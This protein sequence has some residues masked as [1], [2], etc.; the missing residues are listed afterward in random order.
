MMVGGA[1]VDN[2]FAQSFG[3][4]YSSDA[5]SAVKLAEKLIKIKRGMSYGRLFKI[6]ILF[7]GR[8]ITEALGGAFPYIVTGAVIVAIWIY[9]LL[10]VPKKQ[11]RY[12]LS[13]ST[14][15]M[16]LISD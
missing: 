10:V 13:Q 1:V 14:C 8:K 11:K 3:A 4:H 12:A 9:F 16:F 15:L 7:N 2:R 5:Y 6:R